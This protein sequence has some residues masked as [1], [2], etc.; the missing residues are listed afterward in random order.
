MTHVAMPVEWRVLV[1]VHALIETLCGL[2]D[3]DFY[4][5]LERTTRGMICGGGLGS[6]LHLVNLLDECRL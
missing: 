5:W 1:N 4:A 2:V 6:V 3:G